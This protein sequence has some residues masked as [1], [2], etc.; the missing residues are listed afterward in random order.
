MYSY[1]L[2]SMTKVNKYLVISIVSLFLLDS[3]FIHL[4][5]FSLKSFTALSAASFFSGHIYKLLLYPIIAGNLFEVIFDGLILWF[6]GSQFESTWGVRRYLS[7]LLTC[8]V[9][10]GVLLLLIGLFFSSSSFYYTYLS[11]MNGVAGALC[12]I[13]GILFPNRLMYFFFFPLKAKY[14]VMILVGMSLYQGV[15][16]P[17]FVVVWGSLGSYLSGFLWLV[18]PKDFWKSKK[19]SIKKKAHLK[20]VKR[21]EEKDDIT[22]H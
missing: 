11:G 18:S 7:L 4:L 6:I 8:S 5:G 3:I 15:F 12:V 20:L 22:Y 2:P 1:Q 19:E 13:Y 10:G 9:G 14:F 16:S 21:T 17:G